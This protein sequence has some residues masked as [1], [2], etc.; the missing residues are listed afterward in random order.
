MALKAGGA[1]IAVEWGYDIH[2]VILTARNWARVK[3]GG[4]LRIRSPGYSEEGSQW[5]Y[6][7]FAGGLDGDLIVEYGN[8][9]GQGFVGKLR[10]ATIEETK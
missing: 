9:G 3:R 10:D 5:E 1:R 4:S 2:E 6:W 8:D 7:N